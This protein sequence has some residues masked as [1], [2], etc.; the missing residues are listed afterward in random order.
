MN[1]TNQTTNLNNNATLYNI[2]RFFIDDEKTTDIQYTNIPIPQ[3]YSTVFLYDRPY[4]TSDI[5]YSYGND[6]NLIDVYVTSQYDEDD[7]ETETDED[8]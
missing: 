8:E 6:F 5:T 7:D 3:L 2:I 1:N 4:Y